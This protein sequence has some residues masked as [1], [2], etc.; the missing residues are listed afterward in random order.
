MEN[1]RHRLELSELTGFDWKEVD[2]QLNLLLSYGLV[3]IYAESGSM[4]MYRLT[5]QGRLLLKLVEGLSS[6]K[7]K[8]PIEP[9]VGET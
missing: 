2:R 5:E 7:P 4:K 9:S 6:R 8:S 3:T 1:P